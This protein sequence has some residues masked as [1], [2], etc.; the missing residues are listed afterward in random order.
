MIP[1]KDGLE[2]L[3]S[4]GALKATQN[5]KKTC[6]LMTNFDSIMKTIED[7]TRFAVIEKTEGGAFLFATHFS[8][9]HIAIMLKFNPTNNTL[10]I[11]GKSSDL[12][13][14]ASLMASVRDVI[15]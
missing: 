4:A 14:L 5:L 6:L 2:D 9:N 15:M 7:R 8:G 12:P 1:V 3:L 13:T 10:L 11:E